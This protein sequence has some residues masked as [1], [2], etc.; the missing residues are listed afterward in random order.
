MRRMLALGVLVLA[1]AGFVAL[2]A[3]RPEPP[4]VEVRERV[5][6]IAVVQASPQAVRPT[7]TLYGRIEAPDRV[8]ASAPVSG[9]ILE[10]EVRDGDFVEAGAVLARLDPRD[11]QP[12]LEQAR[13]A[14]ERER[15]RVQSDRAALE[16][17]RRLLSLAQAK[18]ERFEKL[19]RQNFGSAATSDQAREEVARARLA[20]TQREQAVAEHPARLAD[21]LATLAAAERDVARG[22]IT[23]P[24]TARIGTV[25]VA[26]GDQVQPGQTVLTLYPSDDLF[27][28][29]RVPAHHV[30][31]L[32]GAL[33][34]GDAL[35]A[36][37]DFG[38]ASLTARLERISGEADARGVEVLLRV[39]AGEAVPVGAFLSAELER[40]EVEGVLSLPFSALHGGD[41]IYRV[42]DGRL[43][44]V[45]VERVGEHRSGGE[46]RVLVRA[47][48]LPSGSTVMVTH[49][50]NAIDGLAVEAQPQ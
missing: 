25:E 3:T 37:A 32:K 19:A 20:V 47:P 48:D 44:T 13:A 28:R 49:L 9:R 6:P 23:A 17:E 36:R 5:W 10:L 22:A 12:R 14:V 2:R 24:F 41:R 38:G 29:A 43:A 40:P 30:A 31:E 4:Q 16:Q 35:L 15:L 50:P 33:A 42:A 11:L 45:R 7:L 1:V 27:L 8:R 26:T 46:P 21:A 39:H 34:A 18:L